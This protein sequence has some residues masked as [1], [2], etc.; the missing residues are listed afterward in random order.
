MAAT[1]TL[2]S[3]SEELEVFVAFAVV[4]EG[5]VVVVVEIAVVVGSEVSGSNDDTLIMAYTY[6]VARAA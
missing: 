6:L 3:G 2:L 5:V 1:L 4:V